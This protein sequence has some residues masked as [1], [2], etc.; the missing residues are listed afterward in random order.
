MTFQRRSKFNAVK[1]E[2]DGETFDSKRELKR[3]L[4]LKLLERAGEIHGLERQVRIPLHALG[5]EKVGHY[6]A[7]FSYVAVG[8]G[9]VTED[10]KG[11]R[12]P[13]YSWKARHFKAEYGREIVES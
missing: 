7:D 1:V 6:V 2:H 9:L 5:G 12:T 10:A 8:K 3:W 11:M 13:L 4:E